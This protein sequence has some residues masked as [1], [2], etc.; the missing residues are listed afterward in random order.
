MVYKKYI[1]RKGKKFGPYYFKSVREKD[2]SVKSVYLGKKHPN[3]NLF[4]LIGV[5]G[6]ALL[7]SLVGFVSYNAFV[8]TDE[9][10][11][12]EGISDVVEQEEEIVEEEVLEELPE[13]EVVEEEIVEEPPEEEII[14][15]LIDEG[16]IDIEEESISIEKEVVVEVVNETEINIS[17]DE[18]VE[19]NVTEENINESIIEEDREIQI[20]ETEINVTEDNKTLVNITEINES[21]S[22]NDSIIIKP[23]NLTQENYTLEIVEIVSPV[24]INEPVKVEKIITADK[25]VSGINIDLPSGASDISILD[26]SDEVKIG[27]DGRK[28]R[29]GSGNL[30]T[31]NVAL[32]FEGSSFLDFLKDIFRFTGFV[33]YEENNNVIIKDP[34]K[35]VKVEYYLPGPVSI[36]NDL[37]NGFKEIFISSDINYTNVSVYSNIG[38]VDGHVNVRDSLGKEIAY[39]GEDLDGDGN[40]DYIEWISATS[41]NNYTV[42][43]TILN[44][45]SF[46]VV[47]LNWTVMFNT[48][49]V[50][51]LRITPV[52]DTTWGIVGDANDL[53]F[54]DVRC[55]DTIMDSY[56]ENGSIVVS[57]YSCNETGVES[58]RVRTSG[59]HYLEFDFGGQVAHA[60]NSAV[61]GQYLNSDTTLTGDLIN[62]GNPGLGV[63]FSQGDFTVDCAGFTIDGTKTGYGFFLQNGHN[64]TLKNCTIT[65]FA[66]GIYSNGNAYGNLII[67]NTIHN[68]SDRGIILTDGDWINMENNSIIDNV[69]YDTDTGNSGIEIQRGRGYNISGNH[70]YDVDLHG[71]Y[72]YYVYNSTVAYNLIEDTVSSQGS[73]IRAYRNENVTYYGNNITNPADYGLRIEGTNNSVFD[74]NIITGSGDIG[75]Y[76]YSAASENV[77]KNND[78]S[79]MDSSYGIYLIHTNTQ[80]NVI[81]N[82]SIYGSPLSGVAVGLWNSAAGSG[83]VIANNS[84]YE[85]T[86]RGIFT[87][88]PDTLIYNNDIYNNTIVGIYVYKGTGPDST[89][90]NISHN[91]IYENTQQGIFTAA[92]SGIIIEYNN[93]TDNWESAAYGGNI[94]IA[95]TDDSILRGNLISGGGHMGVRV[96]GTHTNNTWDS[97][98]IAN[99]SQQTSYPEVYFCES[100]PS[101]GCANNTWIGNTLDSTGGI[102][103]NGIYILRALDTTLIDNNIIGSGNDLYLDLDSNRTTLINST[104]DTI[105]LESTIGH[106]YWS[107]WYLDVHVNT[108][109]GD[110]ENANVSVF[111]NTGLVEFSELTDA[112]GDVSRINLTEYYYDASTYT[113]FSNYTINTTSPSG[114]YGNDSREVNLTTNV[115][116]FITLNTLNSAP[117]DPSP[118]LNSVDGLNLTSS[119]LNCSATISDPDSD[120]LDVSVRWYKDDVLNLTVDYN[121]SYTSGILF[122]A[123]LNS[124][125]TTTGETWNCSMKLNDGTVD[126]NWVSSAGLTILNS[127]PVVDNVNITPS[128]P[129]TADNLLGYCN[130]SDSNSDN[131]TYYYEWYKDG[132]LN[133]SGN[134]VGS[135]GDGHTDNGDGTCT[136]TLRPDSAGDLTQLPTASPDVA[137]YLNVDESSADD[138]SSFI[139]STLD[140][141]GTPTARTTIKENSVVSYDSNMG[142]SSSYGTDSWTRNNR[143]SDNGAWTITDVDALQIGLNVTDSVGNSETDIFNLPAS[144]IP[145]DST[146]NNVVT[147]LRARTNTRGSTNVRATQVY[148][149]VTYTPTTAYHLPG[150]EVNVN[151]LSSSLTS[152]GENWTFNCMAFD[153]TDNASVWLNTSVIIQ[154]SLPEQVT[155]SS[156]ENGNETTDRTPTLTWSA[157]T[158]NDSDSLT[159]H[160][161]V[162]DSAGGIIYNQTDVASTSYT[163]GS[164]LTLDDT[165]F[166]Y[167]RANDGEG[168]GTSSELWNFTV[169]SLVT[170]SATTSSI[171]FG[172]L[173]PGV[174]D[175]TTDD[176]PA[177]FVIQND[178][179]SLVNIS[180]NASQ[181]FDQT[182]LDNDPYQFKIDNSTETGSF[183]WLTSVINWLNMPSAAVVAID[184]L[185][186]E[187]ATD[188]AEVDILV[189]VPTDELAGSKS[190]TVYFEAALAE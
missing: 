190:S 116:E 147:Y 135:C 169:N 93:H 17:E 15:E 188:T 9:I 149:E 99:N 124:A 24:R 35:E 53:M 47:G 155:L 21:R 120:A 118:V 7:L 80:N 50:A 11:S 165:Y 54:L 148:A 173:G 87:V 112:S 132:V 62:C 64:V 174:T 145:T 25:V 162:N 107:K 104:P 43:I 16:I 75:V 29:E 38:N 179:N 51:D 6:I 48:T 1:Y 181:L 2:G 45:Q 60:Q 98:I 186:Y 61:C 39:I 158:D 71:I 171:S 30:V 150:V 187:D 3:Y 59:G 57:N 175:N 183:N 33:V 34:V 106:H 129:Y 86:Q 172:S 19:E 31:G 14:E 184:S 157:P 110:L 146:V 153:G 46:P 119:D 168:F 185:K 160:V 22:I 5:I 144:N 36:E 74:S 41:E 12:E 131:V 90:T 105:F 133:N 109:D 108:S 67:N 164:D 68:N 127:A 78:I 130:A 180:V 137:H 113:Y 94:Q 139:A 79:N 122:N 32:D 66:Y 128:L 95:N 92:V 13:E 88:T 26:T 102:G 154:N 89:G 40:V 177:P 76:F 63:Q 56:W 143:P 97:N 142:L 44:F 70:I 52:N 121:N 28:V 114:T 159:Y 140:G 96:Y 117:S 23:L 170:I 151:N 55:G 134:L 182:A 85:N 91:R 84:I 111:N 10:I 18:V 125:N 72:N 20:N 156:P 126:S 101:T 58:S 136:V 82:N 138:D 178:G 4:V 115:A 152:K 167:V 27:L 37:G 161:F 49:G 163:F 81:A 83:N 69:I 42:S 8:V 189:T 103:N 176:S 141:L 65:E 123:T 166:W 100:T 73:G 77:L